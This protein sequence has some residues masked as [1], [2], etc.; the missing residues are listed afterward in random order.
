[1]DLNIYIIDD[2]ISIRHIIK[3]IIVTKQLGYVVG[4]C[5]DGEQALQDLFIL[6]PDIIIV[7]LLLPALD[8]IE[9][10]MKAKTLSQQM[11]F[12][13]VSQVTAK[14]M[15]ARAYDGGIEYFINKPINVNEVVSVMKKVIEKH[16]ITQTLR[17]IESAF[18][19]FKDIN[20][21]R[22]ISGNSKSSC[23]DKV[24]LILSQ[25]GILGE[26]GSQDIIKILEILS[27]NRNG[28]RNSLP[29]YKTSDIYRL[30]SHHYK[31]EKLQEES[32]EKAIEQ[33]VR[34]AIAKALK[35]IA[36]IGLEDFGDVVF[37]TYSNSIFDFSEVRTEMEYIKGK[38]KYRGKINVKKFL[39]GI[40]LYAQQS[41]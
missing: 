15:I 26:S 20:S 34:R 17:H 4:E 37:S 21:A 31:E 38:N 40:I 36:S 25:L 41:M 1:M 23:E 32:S 19:I 6:K 8:G 22:E 28:T 14:D 16:R 7:D 30:L 12:V 39:E 3:N 2:D 18:H 27:N 9:L 10:V 5:D 33:R 11:L 24:K 29:R 13:M 35:N